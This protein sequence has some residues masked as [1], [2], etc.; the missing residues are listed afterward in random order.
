MNKLCVHIFYNL[1][2]LDQFFEKH[3]LLKHT[4]E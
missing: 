2:E 3:N 4:Q 1:D